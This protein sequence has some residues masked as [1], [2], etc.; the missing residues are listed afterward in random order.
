MLA[1]G[2]GTPCAVHIDPVEKKPLYHMYPGEKT[3]SIG[4]AGCNLRCKNCQNYSISQ[5][6]PLKTN[7]V[8]MTP[9]DAVDEA[10]KRGCRIIA[11]TYSEPSVWIEYVIDTSLLARKKGLKTVLVS[12]GYINHAPFEDLASVIDGA[13][14]DL[15]SFDD[16]VYRNLNAGSLEPVLQTLKTARRKGVWLEIVNLIVPRWNDN[17]SMIREMCKWIYANLGDNTPLHFSRFFPMYKLAD[18]YPTPV[19]S[20]LNARKIAIDEK[21]KF[22]YIGN[23]P[24]IDS[25]TYCPSC[26]KLLVE[27]KGYIATTHDLKG[28][29][30]A[31]CGTEVSG[32]WNL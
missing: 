28:G 32:M 2:Y 30:C 8:E 24:D 27:R 7:N 19:E 3:L 6:S 11:F 10:V 31:G 18:L 21:L 1:L 14:I 22:V 9:E 23:V 20:L 16:T 12:S 13:N 17:M 25:N 29:C 5:S 15:K 26:R 4:I